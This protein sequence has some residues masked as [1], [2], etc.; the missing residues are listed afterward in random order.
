[1][2]HDLFNTH[3][4]RNHNP[5]EDQMYEI[6][7]EF[8]GNYPAISDPQILP[9]YTEGTI[10]YVSIPPSLISDARA[11]KI[12]INKYLNYP[13]LLSE[14]TLASHPEDF[15][16]SLK[17]IREEIDNDNLVISVKSSPHKE[18][19]IEATRLI[20]ST[21]DPVDREIPRYLHLQM[22]LE[23]A[24]QI[25]HERL[26]NEKVLKDIRKL[27]R[28]SPAFATIISL[29]LTNLS[30][31]V[32]NLN[33]KYD[34][35]FEYIPDFTKNRESD[36]R[37]VNEVYYTL[38][39]G[40]VF[41]KLQNEKAAEILIERFPTEKENLYKNA[42]FKEKISPIIVFESAYNVFQKLFERKGIDFNNFSVNKLGYELEN[43]ITSQIITSYVKHYTQF[44]LGPSSVMLTEKS[45]QNF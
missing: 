39:R 30:P 24:E 23:L 38:Q 19:V 22:A 25:V 11:W 36:R 32:K 15:Q 21:Q 45:L 16:L 10:P 8:L 14:H 9:Q 44:S 13:D 40:N 43:T 27:A 17:T 4:G 41:S 37:L 20:L 1:M 7:E 29:Q 31:I 42:S 2:N 33:I 26:S 18:K 6:K 3:Q 34:D 5:I 12:V 35:L 28:T